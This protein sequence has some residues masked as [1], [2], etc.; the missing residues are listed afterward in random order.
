MPAP[1]SVQWKVDNLDE[2]E[3][4]LRFHEFRCRPDGDDL[5]I[6]GYGGLNTHLAPGDSL[7]LDGDRLGILRVPAEPDSAGSAVMV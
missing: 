6:Q 5:L 3:H 2:I 4:L 7:I 1:P